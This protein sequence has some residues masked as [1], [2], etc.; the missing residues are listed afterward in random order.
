LLV[1]SAL[2]GQSF[3]PEQVRAMAVAFDHACQSLGLTSVPD[4]LT[5]IIAKKIVDTAKAGESDPVRLYE[6]VMHWAS[7]A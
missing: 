2:A 5:D 4:Q 7:V 1:S 6:A 3:E